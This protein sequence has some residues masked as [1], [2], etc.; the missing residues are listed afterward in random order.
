MKDQRPA[1][2]EPE[3]WRLFSL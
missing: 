1:R 3:G 2:D